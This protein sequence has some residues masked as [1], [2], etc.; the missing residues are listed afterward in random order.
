MSPFVV[1]QSKWKF[2]PPD[3]KGTHK[4]QFAAPV[5]N[6]VPILSPPPPAELLRSWPWGLFGFSSPP[7]LKQ[8]S[9][10]LVSLKMAAERSILKSLLPEDIN[11]A[12]AVPNSGCVGSASPSRS[13][14]VEGAVVIALAAAED[15]AGVDGGWA[16]GDGG[17][18]P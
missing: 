11:P 5:P 8:T 14:L 15:A 9:V 18:A 12:C 7:S 16:I 3:R 17:H 6:M 10:I 13:I 2:P 1:S 4:T